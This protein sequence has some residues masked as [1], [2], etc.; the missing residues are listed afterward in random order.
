MS[1]V[2]VNIASQSIALFSEKEIKAVIDASHARGVKVAAHCNNNA[3]IKLVA[4][5]G[6]DSIEHGIIMDDSTLKVLRDS[7]VIWNPTLAAYFSSAGNRWIQAKQTYEKALKIPEIK[8]ACGGDTGV[9]NH[10]E[11]SLELKLMFRSG[12]P[13]NRILQAATLGG[14]QCVR[15]LNWEGSLGQERLANS[16]LLTEDRRVVGENE[17]PF[18]IIRPGFAADLIATLT[19]LRDNFESAIS[20]SG[21][22]FVMKGGVTYKNGGAPVYAD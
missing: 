2:S 22:T 1:L 8:I 18:G 14:W 6:V 21:I 10:G 12:A 20:S 7:K 5:L 11:N 15:S 9:F 13:W 17:M 3:S 16:H 4:S 19:S